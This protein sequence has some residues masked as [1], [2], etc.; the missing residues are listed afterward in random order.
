M[1]ITKTILLK[2]NQKDTSI[3]H[4]GLLVTATWAILN[5]KYAGNEVLSFHKEITETG[6]NVSQETYAEVS[7]HDQQS[8][9]DLY[10]GIERATILTNGHQSW[11]I[12][13]AAAMAF[14]FGHPSG[15]ST[16]VV[17]N[18]GDGLL[19]GSKAVHH[20]ILTMYT[21]KETDFEVS[22]HFSTPTDC[23]KQA[24]RIA[25]QFEHILRE[26]YM[27]TQDTPVSDIDIMSPA[28]TSDIMHW[29]ATMPAS[30]E[31][32]V[33]ESITQQASRT[34]SAPALCA[35][36]GELTYSQL[37]E[38]TSK[39][40]AHLVGLGVGPESLVPV[41][42]EKSMWA[43]VAMLSIL[44]AGG[45]CVPLDPAHPPARRQVI[46][47][48]LKASVVLTSL[49]HQNLFTESALVSVVVDSVFLGMLGSVEATTLPSASPG[50]AV[51]VV[52][53]S[54]STGQPK[55]IVIEHRAM[56]TSARDHGIAMRF[57]PRSR[58]LQFA[59][60]TFDDSFSDIF[61]TLMFGGCICIPSD[62]DRLDN[63]PKA[64][65]DFK[66]N[67]A[68]LTVTV[69][70]QLQPSD[71]PSLEVL[72]VGGEAVTDAVLQQWSD[73]VYLINGY[74]P[75]E[76]SIFCS[77]K[78]GLSKEDDASNV[79]TA[80]GCLLWITD[81]TDHN[82]LV[83][84]GA[85]GELLVEGPIV[86]RG[87]LNNEEKTKS[88][89]IVNPAW[90]ADKPGNQKRRLYK[91]GDLARYNPDGT[92]QVLGRKDTQVK[93]RGQRIELGEI[94]HR[95]HQYFQ[96]TA[97]VAVEMV[98]PPNGPGVP[99][100]VAIICV[101]TPSQPPLE[102][103][104]E[105]KLHLQESL[106]SYMI[107][108]LF[109]PL[110]KMPQLV[111]GKL[112]RKKLRQIATEAFVHGHGAALDPKT[113]MEIVLQKLWAEILGLP[114]DSITTRSDFLRIGGDSFK[115]MA[116]VSAL[117]REGFL[118]NVATILQNLEL[119]AQAQAVKLAQAA[120]MNTPAFSLAG[121]TSTVA[122]L[123]R[124]IKVRYKIKR[125]LIEDMY[126]C[127]PQ[128][129]EMAMKSLQ[130]P[131]SYT[132][133]FVYSIPETLDLPKFKHAWEAVV[134]Q[135]P[136][137]RTRFVETSIGLFQLVLR[138]SPVSFKEGINC[139]SFLIQDH[140][141]PLILHS[142]TFRVAIIDSGNERW[143]IFTAHLSICDSSSLQHIF[144]G[145]AREYDGHHMRAAPGFNTFIQYI[146]QPVVP[147][148]QVFWNQE[149]VDLPS[150]TYP[151]LPSPE[152]HS[153]SDSWLELTIQSGIVPASETTT[154][155]MLRAVMAIVLA[156]YGSPQ[157]VIF[158]TFISGRNVQIFQMEDIVGPTGATVPLL[159]PVNEALSINK[160]LGQIEE[161]LVAMIPYE[162]TYTSEIKSVST[163]PGYIQSLLILESSPSTP[164][165]ARQ[166]LGL[167]EVTDASGTASLPYALCVRCKKVPEGI[168]ARMDFDSKVISVE[169]ARL[170]LEQFDV[171]FRQVSLQ[172][173]SLTIEQIKK[174]Q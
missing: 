4:V 91:T 106:P 16:L 57:T 152:Y 12:K 142:E 9:Q 163:E 171:V 62:D 10:D 159:I 154:T 24:D 146:G 139:Y 47:D 52:F 34:P 29:N 2:L 114:T 6:S 173:P 109:I 13:L 107:P 137:L 151:E 95:I 119:S 42:F 131:G 127:T 128:Q 51:F 25:G 31:T 44:K 148:P 56:C 126:R 5:A 105:L 160:F 102:Q 88:S 23:P 165:D 64:I 125:Q 15:H 155:V 1:E 135:T 167:R 21:K 36:D 169:Q 79:G 97:E 61:T 8:L 45:A 116:L 85:V 3:S 72:T 28:D 66:A 69:A 108:S 53:T 48:D 156:Q 89:F 63:L 80:W 71:N 50:N 70:R 158:D 39:L 27:R 138:E 149:L 37:E 161:Q 144:E 83:P 38:M 118:C 162:Q 113:E 86:A 143:F 121:D 78:T 98:S 122:K 68:C 67:Q 145:L 93:L 77:G 96:T 153:L 82:R 150:S 19:R 54:G 18:G 92:I 35:W 60:Y 133:R 14:S 110:E 59:A 147:E 43:I 49:M 174:L 75:A 58:V 100:L 170:F 90:L 104:D 30:E 73:S 101:S 76:C 84:V 74:G 111:S 141:L 33:H 65:A 129:E 55:G 22:V 81:A 132:S 7:V 136:I 157:K 124:E 20:S 168:Q 41:C 26:L 46:L 94:E 172:S 117:Q 130:R 140:Q 32:L 99:K 134:K 123:W 112:D 166:V 103:M 164:E 17:M 40:A 87:Y 115:A 120:V 11:S